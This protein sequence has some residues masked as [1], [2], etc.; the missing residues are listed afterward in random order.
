MA[1][2]ERK[3]EGKKLLNLKSRPIFSL[4]I[5]RWGLAIV[6]GFLTFDLL[7]L[8]TSPL[9]LRLQEAP[10]GIV[11][12]TTRTEFEPLTDYLKYTLILVGTF[13][14]FTLTYW[15][16]G[17]RLLNRTMRRIIGV[18]SSWDGEDSRG[19]GSL[20]VSPGKQ[21]EGFEITNNQNHPA[22]M[23]CRII[24]WIGLLGVLVIVIINLTETN[25]AAP[26]EDTF[27]LGEYL[28]FLPTALEKGN[29]FEN[30]FLI[31]GFG[32][33]IL[34]SLIAEHLVTDDNRIALTELV[35]VSFLALSY[36]MALI[37]ITMAAGLCYPRHQPWLRLACIASLGLVGLK[38]MFFL[39]SPNARDMVF[40]WQ[41]VFLLGFFQVVRSKQQWR[42]TI[43]AGLV[44]A[45]LPL[46]FLWHY[47]R[48]IYM[49]LVVVLVSVPIL[50]LGRQIMRSWLIGNGVGI[51]VG[52][53][54][55][56]VLAGLA[57]TGQIV[58]QVVYWSKYAPY[59][60]S[61]PLPT[62][63][64]R[65]EVGKSLGVSV[66]VQCFAVVWLWHEYRQSGSLRTAL[67]RNMGTITLLAATMVFQRMAIGRSDGH[68]FDAAMP[69]ILLIIALVTPVVERSLQRRK[70]FRFSAMFPGNFLIL[71]L[72]SAFAVVQGVNF[73]NLFKAVDILESYSVSY[74]T[75]D[76]S[77]VKSDYQQAV[78]TLGQE[79]RASSC[80]F[81]M[82]SEGVWY[83]LFNQP[84][85][86]RFHHLVYAR[87]LAAQEE[88]V[89][90]LEKTKPSLI[91]FSN[92]FWS[93]SI[94]GVS[95]F[96]S[97]ALVTRYVMKHYQP[98]QLIGS[99]WFW[100]HQD[101]SFRLGTEL[102][103]T[104]DTLPQ[105]ATRQNDIVV[106]GTLKIIPTAPEQAAIFVSWS[107]NNELIAVQRGVSQNNGQWQWR[108][109][110]PTAALPKGENQLRFWFMPEPN[111][112]LY[113]LSELEQIKIR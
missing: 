38:N 11:S 47:E 49:I 59:I 52:L 21:G 26:W 109:P 18:T 111:G 85:C 5:L 50:L 80:F 4:D 13:I 98:Y 107:E 2:N 97:N 9:R 31:H 48:A 110:V 76:S 112:I 24:G 72:V 29:V 84:S 69:S 106:S 95:I 55:L 37:S 10:D 46:S 39:S 25:L 100:H 90:D 64:S 16:L 28:G 92:N 113:P 75:P 22:N 32:K 7:M 36:A 45:S 33:D 40:L 108:I 71:L 42:A 99:H 57:G 77:I 1:T 81:T 79:V 19:A 27:H 12:L 68:L 74:T 86:S 51:F 6:A 93:N 30:T 54:F 58:E 78:A 53:G 3:K 94:D 103:G 15:Q 96:N 23:Q 35:N 65:L 56:V 83:Y 67:A 66:L 88:L 105:E 14:A 20:C 82:T 102:A 34:P 43:A 70:I 61:L 44:G 17:P 101:I 8:I 104:L 41:L 60:W 63:L 89:A 62:G 73:A 91:L 87:N